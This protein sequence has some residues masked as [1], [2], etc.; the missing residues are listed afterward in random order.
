M[1]ALEVGKVLA[2]IVAL[3]GFLRLLWGLSGMRIDR[4]SKEFKLVFD[5]QPQISY[6]AMTVTILGFGVSFL[7]QVELNRLAYGPLETISITA[8]YFRDGSYVG[9][10]NLSGCKF[11]IE[12][13]HQTRPK[14]GASVN[15][16]FYRPNGSFRVYN[17]EQR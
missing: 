16:R 5:G 9:E 11:P 4:S 6:L 3:G 13:M 14:I 10:T 12:F 17:W 15:A 7:C 8:V 2:V 1:N